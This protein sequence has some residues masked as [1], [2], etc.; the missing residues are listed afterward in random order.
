MTEGP[1]LLVGGTGTV[2]SMIATELAGR[3]ELRG[4]ARSDDAAGRLAELGVEPVMGDLADPRSIRRAL[5]GTATMYVATPREGQFDNEWNAIDAAEAERVQ[6]IVRVSI[7]YSGAADTIYVRRPH[8]V[9]DE[10]LLRSTVRSTILQPSTF[11]T[12]FAMQRR[13][14]AEGTMCFPA[15]AAKIAF[16]DPWDVAAVAAAV[17]D[18]TVQLDGAHSVTGPEAISSYEAAA[19][20]GARIGKVVGVDGSRDR[21]RKMMREAGL[22]HALVEGL[23]EIWD[24][25][26]RR[27]TMPVAHTV[28]R[29]LDRRPRTVEEFT[30][31][32]LAGSLA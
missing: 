9:L 4:L 7:L 27:G 13:L 3:V 21:Y 11:M 30:D 16:V 15:P 12:H 32:V 31:D 10:R 26:A 1:V 29:V 14:I 17:I 8:H 22:T 2:G 25:F 24:D 20:I 6:R 23:V 5:R 28:D 18:G 19:R